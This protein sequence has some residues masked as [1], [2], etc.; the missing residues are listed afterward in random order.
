MTFSTLDRWWV[1]KHTVVYHFFI[2]KYI[3]CFSPLGQSSLLMKDI[4][5][6]WSKL[7]PC[8]LSVANWCQTKDT[9]TSSEYEMSWNSSAGITCKE[10]LWR[11]G[12]CF[13]LAPLWV[14]F[15]VYMGDMGLFA[16]L[17]VTR[18][19]FAQVHRWVNYESMLKECL[20]GRMAT[21]IKGTHRHRQTH[22]HT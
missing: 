22:T 19:F 9:C 4:N 8:L 3:D 16:L 21:A 15:N 20:V 7:I 1:V 5:H 17:M 11:T 10:Y 14:L 18:L 13:V 12:T 2:S 6:G